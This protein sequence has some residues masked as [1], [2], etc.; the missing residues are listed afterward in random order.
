MSKL[1]CDLRTAG[2]L[3]FMLEHGLEQSER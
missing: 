1:K 2:R 3:L